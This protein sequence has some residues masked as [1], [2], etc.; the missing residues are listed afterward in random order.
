[1]KIKEI[2]LYRNPDLDCFTLEI[3][4][5]AINI[6]YQIKRFNKVVI[7]LP[8]I[9]KK[10]F[11]EKGLKWIIENV[12]DLAK[13]WVAYPGEVIIVEWSQF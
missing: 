2:V 11:N 12:K 10:I 3:G 4:P 8:Q 13:K 6:P 5:Y 9:L 1:M 7:K